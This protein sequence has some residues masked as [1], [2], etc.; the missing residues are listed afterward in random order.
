MPTVGWKLETAEERY[1]EHVPAPTPEPAFLCPYCPER[2]MDGAKYQEHLGLDHPLELPAMIVGGGA[3][4]S[5]IIIRRPIT[6]RDVHIANA[7]A[8][9]TRRI[10]EHERAITAHDL[11]E[12]LSGETCSR[13][14]IRLTNRRVVDQ[15]E[16]ERR[17][18]IDFRIPAE[19]EL[20]QVDKQF[21]RCLAVD[22]PRHEDLDRFFTGCPPSAVVQD[23][24]GALGDYVLGIIVKE[25]G[26]AIHAPL[27]FEEFRAKYESSREVLRHFDRPVARAVTACVDF[28]LNNF[29]G[30]H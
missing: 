21:I 2:F 1:W 8:C 5:E 16:A 20:N 4:L 18:L 22:K 28:N 23:Y 9:H 29:D 10:G 24:V 3:L 13:W 26:H 11:A 6:A 27:G 30:A 7:T 19:K 25:E 17:Y 14:E 15:E 12:L